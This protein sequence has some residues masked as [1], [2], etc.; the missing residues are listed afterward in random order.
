[1]KAIILNQPKDFSIKEIEL[2]DL[3][4]DEVLIKIQTS[5]I[6]TNDVRD[7]N[8]DCNYSYPRIGGHEYCGTIARLGSE[9]NQSRFQEGQKVV[10]YIIDDCKEC[11]FCKHGEEN[12]CEEHPNSKIFH[13]PDGLSGYGGF[14]E[15]VI[16]KAEDLFV[17]PE[18][19]PFENMAFTEPLACVV[20]SIDRTNIK[21]GDDVVVI[22]GGTMGLLHVI[23]AKMKGARVILSEPLEERRK[24][25]LSLGCDDVVDPMAEDAVKAVK[26][27]TEGRGALVVFN[28]T[29]IPAIAA[30]AVE[31]TAPTGT[32]VMFSSIHPNK[33]VPVD[34]GAVHSYQK[35]VTG[36]VSPTISSFHQAVQLIGKRLVDPTVLTEAVIDYK[37][38]DQAIAMASRPDT[39]KVILNFGE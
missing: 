33:P 22:G 8:G 28:T 19:T 10:Q 34:M 13:N 30:Q 32:T 20:N 29:A 5:G 3:K 7:F 17:Y 37:D 9:V 39:Y 12:I 18:D 27:M 26:N 14:A 31:M 21:F 35:T 23:L 6:C 36:A 38:F 4:A 2:P 1:M 24:K 16:A 25:A 11:Y 15:Y